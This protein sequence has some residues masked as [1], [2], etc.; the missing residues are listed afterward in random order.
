MPA[1]LVPLS[2]WGCNGGTPGATL[3]G[4]AGCVFL[5]RSS[6]WPEFS[7]FNGEKQSNFNVEQD[8][9]YDCSE[10]LGDFRVSWCQAMS[11]HVCVILPKASCC[12][13]IPMSLVNQ[14]SFEMFWLVQMVQSSHAQR[15]L[16][17][18]RRW[19]VKSFESCRRRERK[20]KSEGRCGLVELHGDGWVEPRAVFVILALLDLWPILFPFWDGVSPETSQSLEPFEASFWPGARGVGAGY[21]TAI[22]WR[23]HGS[24]SCQMTQWMAGCLRKVLLLASGHPVYSGLYKLPSSYLPILILILILV[25]ILMCMY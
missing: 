17:A 6:P 4:P 18:D 5:S 21:A 3:R 23:G 24:S 15:L 7:Y 20:P 11:E 8:R 16:M 2:T 1:F 12:W 9:T 14:S 25:L 19:S 10:F 13:C 22:C